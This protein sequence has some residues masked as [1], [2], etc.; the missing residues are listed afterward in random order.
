MY[1]LFRP[2]TPHCRIDD[3]KVPARSI[4]PELADPRCVAA[5]AV[6]MFQLRPIDKQGSRGGTEI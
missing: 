1:L 2:T 3:T 4:A 5:I 6:L